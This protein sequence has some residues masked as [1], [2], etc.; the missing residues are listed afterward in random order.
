MLKA[1]NLCC[2][3]QVDKT[4]FPVF[5]CCQEPAMYLQHCSQC[6]VGTRLLS[7]AACHCRGV[8]CGSHGFYICGQ[9]D[10]TYKTY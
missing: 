2:N 7:R 5:C 8:Q 9:G 6:S 3:F 1:Y 4:I 10:F